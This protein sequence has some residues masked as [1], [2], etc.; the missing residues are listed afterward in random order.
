MS[1]TPEKEFELAYLKY[2]R[3]KIDKQIL[4]VLLESDDLVTPQERE[5]IVGVITECKLDD[6]MSTFAWDMNELDVKINFI[7]N[8]LYFYT[9]L[10][11]E[12]R[13]HDKRR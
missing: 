13:K 3:E 8:M 10:N 5:E 4:D 2:D 7:K 9:N 6:L 11:K 12:R 1:L